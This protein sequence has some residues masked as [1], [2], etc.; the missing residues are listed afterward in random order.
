[1][2]LFYHL[3]HP[4]VGVTWH[5]SDFLISYLSFP[6][7]NCQSFYWSENGLFIPFSTISAWNPQPKLGDS[8]TPSW[9]YWVWKPPSVITATCYLRASLLRCSMKTN[10]S[11]ANTLQNQSQLCTG[12]LGLVGLHLSVADKGLWVQNIHNQLW[13]ILLWPLLQR[14]DLGSTAE[15]NTLCLWFL[16]MEGCLKKMMHSIPGEDRQK[17][18]I[19]SIFAHCKVRQ[20]E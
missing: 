4:I 14:V 8:A 12:H 16:R 2:C 1:M 5:W 6:Y 11:W 20:F 18:Y 15:W 3:P 9:C 13:L 19:L 7:S 10:W 17:R